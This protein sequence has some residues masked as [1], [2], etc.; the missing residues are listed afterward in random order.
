MFKHISHRC[1]GTTDPADLTVVDGLLLRGWV[2]SLG[3]PA[4]KVC[5]SRRTLVL[6]LNVLTDHL[7]LLGGVGGGRQ[8]LLG[9][10]LGLLLLLLT[11]VGIGRGGIS[12]VGIRGVRHRG[13]RRG[14][15]GGL[16]SGWL[17]PYSCSLGGGCGRALWLVVLLLLVVGLVP[18]A[19]PVGG[20]SEVTMLLLLLLLLGLGLLGVLLGCALLSTMVLPTVE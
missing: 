2:R 6:L 3:F 14:S 4:G 8:V 13:S 1:T 19:G 17:V 7:L 18:T 20:V 5:G 12:T 10:L 11:E 15:F 16:Q 9:L